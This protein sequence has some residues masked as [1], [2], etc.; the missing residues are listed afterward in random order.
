MEQAEYVP[1]E[2][3]SLSILGKLKS[4]AGYTESFVIS[5]PFFK[6]Y[7]KTDHLL[8]E[9]SGPTGRV[10]CVGDIAIGI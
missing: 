7:L 3:I 5:A 1:V 4:V 10:F 8:S 6:G 2:D 9:L